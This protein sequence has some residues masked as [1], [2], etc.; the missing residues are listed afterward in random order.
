MFGSLYLDFIAIFCY[1]MTFAIFIAMFFS[2]KKI[3]MF[4][5]LLLLQCYEFT[6]Q[7]KERIFTQDYFPNKTEIPSF[8][9][10]DLNECIYFY[11]L[12]IGNKFKLVICNDF[13]GDYIWEKVSETTARVDEEDS[14]IVT[15]K[16]DQLILPQ[17]NE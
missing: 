12:E 11:E 13:I 10:C 7:V 3:N 1:M 15:F 5:G 17:S 16:I 6:L 14:S 9:Q 8:D 4:L 2:D